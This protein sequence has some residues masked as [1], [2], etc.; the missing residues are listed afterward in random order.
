VQI[1]KYKFDNFWNKYQSSRQMQFQFQ[2]QKKTKSYKKRVIDHIYI[3]KLEYLLL[4][5]IHGNTR[6]AEDLLDNS[7]SRRKEITTPPPTSCIDLFHMGNRIGGFYLVK[8]IKEGTNILTVYRDFNLLYNDPSNQTNK[9][10]I[11]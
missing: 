6:L 4:L 1:K 3:F 10:L 11:K 7:K 5:I 2:V 8:D 9:L